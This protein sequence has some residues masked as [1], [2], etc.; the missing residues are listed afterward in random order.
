[1]PKRSLAT[2]VVAGAV[3]LMDH[4]DVYDQ[5][6]LVGDVGEEQRGVVAY[7]AQ[8]L[9][10]LHQALPYAASRAAVRRYQVLQY[11]SGPVR[12]RTLGPALQCAAE[13]FI[14]SCI[15]L[16]SSAAVRCILTHTRA[17]PYLSA[18]FVRAR[19]VPA[20]LCAVLYM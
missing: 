8:M 9:Q 16:R 7:A 15:T 1:M 6:S 5:M 11:A 3:E 18:V 12:T 4:D 19:H 14:E 13:R 17:T 20:T 2:D 10:Y